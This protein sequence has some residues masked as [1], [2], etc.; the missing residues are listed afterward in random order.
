MAETLISSVVS[1]TT[2]LPA[3]ISN[4]EAAGIGALVTSSTAWLASLFAPDRLAVSVFNVTVD[5]I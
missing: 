5:V 1:S 3:S 4:E 2:L